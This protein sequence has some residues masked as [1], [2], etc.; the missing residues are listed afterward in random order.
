M[1]LTICNVVFC[2]KELQESIAVNVT[3][4]IFVTAYQDMDRLLPFSPSD[5]VV[6]PDFIYMTVELQKEPN[7]LF[8]VQVVVLQTNQYFISQLGKR[9]LSA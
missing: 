3:F 8:F 1:Q 2:R 5:Q 7:T 9:F 4:L 6:I